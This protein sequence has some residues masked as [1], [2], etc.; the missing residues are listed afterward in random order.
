LHFSFCAFDRY[1]FSQMMMMLFTVMSMMVMMKTAT[2]L[3][4]FPC[5]AAIQPTH[6]G[7]PGVGKTRIVSVLIAALTPLTTMRI[8]VAAPT[9][10]AAA[11]LRESMGVQAMT[12]HRLLG[13]VREGDR[14]R[15][16]TDKLKCDLL[17]VDEAS[18][19][20]VDLMHMLMSAMPPQAA[21][22]LVGD[23]DQLPSVGPG[24]VLV[25][26]LRSGVCKVVEL[27]EVHRQAR[28]SNLI[29]IARQIR[30]GD[31]PDLATLENSD[32]DVH[33]IRANR[34]TEA[35]NI[36]ID[37][38]TREIPEALDGVSSRD[39]QVGSCHAQR[40]LLARRVWFH[41]VASQFFCLACR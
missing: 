9:G 40:A 21:L 11:R 28:G 2:M 36:V 20:S 13:V 33:F 35:A 3:I 34:P 16:P 10:R 31:L 18:M 12:L 23:V 17:I 26:L 39:V 5:V 4:A 19:L 38:V 27:T 22:L 7:G 15:D 8:L 6:T 24:D 25:D 37:L 1:W 30:N 29:S 41:Y 14:R 32:G